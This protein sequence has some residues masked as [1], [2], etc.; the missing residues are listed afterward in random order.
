[1]LYKFK[2]RSTADLILLEP[3]GRRLL[4]LI[5]KE[6]GPTGIVTVAQIPAALAA[7]EVA[8]LDDDRRL[9]ARAKE[10]KTLS[11]GQEDDVDDT[12]TQG[13]SV[14]L[15]QR[16]APFIEMLRRS[17]EGGHDVVWGA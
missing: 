8:V 16:A 5:G 17:A 15:H 11:H 2:S 7:L 13:D 9:A 3:H 10:K 12:D 14:S 1:M 4:Q 6:T